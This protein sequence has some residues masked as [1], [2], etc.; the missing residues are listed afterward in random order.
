MED[1]LERIAEEER[2]YDSAS[3]QAAAM[4]RAVEDR[5][6]DV[7]EISLYRQVLVDQIAMGTDIEQARMQYVELAGI[8]RERILS[9]PARRRGREDD[10]GRDEEGDPAGEAR[11]VRARIE[12]ATEQYVSL[13]PSS[14]TGSN[15]GSGSSISNSGRGFRRS[16]G[17]SRRTNNS[18]AAAIIPAAAQNMTYDA[19]T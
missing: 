10:E 4:D 8:L 3:V 14:A 1:R 13:G 11:R 18:P 17:L 16:V 19:T 2:I 6:I 7:E 9:N 15:S 5:R 12:E